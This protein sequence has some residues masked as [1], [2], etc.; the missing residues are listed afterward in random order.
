M[1]QLEKFSLGK[2]LKPKGSIQKIG[3]VGCGAVGQPVVLQ[4]AQ[5]GMDVVFLDVSE[6]RIKEI[7]TDLEMQLDAIIKHWGITASEKRLILSRITGTIKYED[8]KDCDIV[9]ETISSRK[10]GTM[11][12]IR[13]EIFKSIEKFVKK[14]TVIASNL[15]TLMISDLAEVLEHKDRATGVHFIEPIDKTKIVEV[16]RAVETSD[17][18]VELISRFLRMINKRAIVIHESPGNISTRILLPVLNEACEVLME[19]VASVQDIDDTMK[20]IMGYNVGPFELADRIGLDKILKFMDNLYAEYG[21][22][23]YK[24][25]PILKRLVRANYIGKR[26]G[27]GFYNYEGNKPVS[28]TITCAIIK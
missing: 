21:D 5:Y 25:S 9:I 14:S 22:K 1:N 27:K 13:R 24:A 12:E 15:S 2:Q 17:K 10:R 6:E 16:M 19:G 8:F 11:V 7:F 18:T 23:K 20:E 3:I 4:V 26:V 28:N